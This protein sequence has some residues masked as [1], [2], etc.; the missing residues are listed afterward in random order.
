LIILG[1]G[2]VGCEA[3]WIGEAILAIKAE[4]PVATLADLMHPFP[5]YSAAYAPALATLQL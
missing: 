5:T 4:L 3:E 1:G 2:P